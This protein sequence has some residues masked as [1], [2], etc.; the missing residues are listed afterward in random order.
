MVDRV[1]VDASAVE[2]A[3]Q[4]LRD[5]PPVQPSQMTR[6]QAVESM[7]REIVALRKRG[8]SWDQIAQRLSDAG[9][10][11]SAATLKSYMRPAKS[12]RGI[13]AAVPVQQQPVELPSS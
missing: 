12:Q 5:A 4:M 13:A 11:I 9:I 10:T 6:R 7:R 8:Y 1:R 3:R 2:A